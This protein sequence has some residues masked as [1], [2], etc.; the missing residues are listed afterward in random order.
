L[1]RFALC[2]YTHGNAAAIAY[3]ARHPE[4]VSHLALVNPWPTG[5]AYFSEIPTARAMYQLRSMA[6]QEWEFFTLSIASSMFGHQK[7]EQAQRTAMLFRSSLSAK[8]YLAFTDSAL[9]LDLRP[10]LS[11]L[12][13]PVLVLFDAGGVGTA[14]LARAVAS[15][16][17]GARLQVAE[18]YPD[19][20]L[21]FLGMSVAEE[22][23]PSTARGHTAGGLQTILFTDIERNT[24]LLQRLGDERW[25]A[26]LRDHERATREQLAAH[27]G[28]EI[29]TLGDGFMA[30]FGSASR[31]VEC[32]IALQKIC[33]SLDTPASS[34]RVRIG[35][36]AGEPIAEDDDL[37]GTAVT[38]AARIMGHAEGGE[39]LVSDVVRQLVAG[40]GFLF[41]DR[42]DTVLRGF[43]D[44]VRLYAVR[45]GE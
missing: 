39:I 11:E 18:R 12:R 5:D 25:R 36:N 35:L 16:I 9:E 38:M 10:Y 33:S 23:A 6:E 44:P 17:D 42:G 27:G 13:A 31:A 14:S 3:A 28:A 45:I 29:K 40:K 8:G 34:L 24:E 22:A 2:G 41:A 32:A 20:V 21:S 37:F 43:D 7:P 1:E 19:E 15:K 30:A 4:R 26:L